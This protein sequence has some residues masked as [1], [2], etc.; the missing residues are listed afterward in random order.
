MLQ[1]KFFT[2]NIII[3]SFDFSRQKTEEKQAAQKY[4][5]ETLIRPPTTLQSINEEQQTD[6]NQNDSWPNTNT[7]TTYQSAFQ[8][9]SRRAIS[10]FETTNPK[11]DE[12]IETIKLDENLRQR[13][14]STSLIKTPLKR[15]SSKHHVDSLQLIDDNQDHIENEQQT[16]PPKETILPRIKGLDL[17]DNAKSRKIRELQNKLSR[18]EEEAKKQFNELQS[19]Q[20]RLENALKLLV[21]QTK[22]RSST[23]DDSEIPKGHSAGKRT[24][25][26]SQC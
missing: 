12:E 5:K 8:N 13:P 18:Q 11:I 24:A 2:Y 22:P 19:K 1:S 25:F 4:L 9:Y 16:P 6:E 17:I 20:S 21:K 7:S 3:S 23:Q 14:Q 10:S 26:I 15:P